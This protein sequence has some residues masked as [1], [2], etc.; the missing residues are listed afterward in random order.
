MIDAAA[1]EKLSDDELRY[2]L[3]Q[4]KWRKTARPNQLPPAGNW[5]EWGLQAGRGFGKTRVGAEWLGEQAVIS[6]EGLPWG[7]IAPTLNDVRFTCFEGHSGLLNVIP[8]ELVADYNK[9]NLQIT[10]RT[11]SGKLST[12]RGFSAEEP[13]RLRGPQSAGLWCDEVA[14]WG[15]DEATWDMAM[16]GNRLGPYPRVVWTST[17]KPKTFIR[18]LTAPKAGRIITRGSTYENRANLAD[19]FFEQLKKYEGTQLGRQ[20]LMG[21]MIDAEEGGIIN[22]SWMRLWPH[23]KPLPPF[24][25]IIVSLDTAFT[26]RTLNKKTHDADSS[27]CT[28]W[29]TFMHEDVMQVMLL[30]CW[31]EQLGLPDLIKHAKKAMAQAYGG[32]DELP[33]IKPLHGPRRMA[34]TGRKPDLLL[35]EDKGSGISLRQSLDREGLRAYP[36]NPGRADKT[37][38]LHIVSHIFSGGFV[39]LPESA[40]YPGRARTWVEPMLEQLCTFRGSGSIKHDDYV[41]STT[42]AIRFFLDKRMLSGVKSEKVKRR[43]E[44]LPEDRPAP[45]KPVVNPYTQ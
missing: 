11:L 38:R 6:P 10:V 5:T 29:G 7:V 39:W 31:A 21:D 22:R 45:R 12:I 4:A 42:Q 1:L 23:A 13:E 17:P 2:V 44:G 37:A 24:H 32:E 16:F 25:M 26:E 15:E 27:A 8:P 33:V 30:D 40:K 3:W 36:Y 9:S 14:A 18:Q 43:E 20:E 34:D 19:V 35:I 28:V 41:D